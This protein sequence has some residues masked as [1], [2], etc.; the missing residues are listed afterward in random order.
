MLT[1]D[2]I[3]NAM[4][5][6]VS[7]GAYSAEEVDAFLKT[8]AESHEQ[9]LQ[10]NKE[11]IKK[12]SI[13]ADKLESYR[14]DEEAI[15]L[16]LLDARRLAETI[17]KDAN[18]KA[19][20]VVADAEAKSKVIIDDATAQSNQAIAEARE[21]AK[22]IVDNARVAVTAL[23]DR[24]QNETEQAI[25]AA[26][27]KATE[28]VL[29]AEAQGREIIGRSKADFEYY[30][31]ELERIRKETETYKATAEK[32]CKEQLAL[33]E[34]VKLPEIPV[35][36]KA[37][38]VAEVVAQPVVEEA[39]VADAETIA[40]EAVVEESISEEVAV[41]VSEEPAEAPAESEE[42]VLDVLDVPVYEEPVEAEESE[43][44]DND[45]LFSMIE[46][47]NFDDIVAPEE[48][49]ATL[50]EAVA[51]QA[52]A[53]SAV[54]DVI[55]DS[56]DEDPEEFE[57]FEID[58]EELDKITSDVDLSEDEDITSLFDSFFNE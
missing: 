4:F 32:L 35:A 23:T 36:E 9:A 26:Q 10:D 37:E 28:I 2:Q 30:S 5:T 50:D 22:E 43:T 7:R 18:I 6:P 42:D 41:L 48:I 13:L 1:T 45:D 14:S 27:Q 17:N 54:A 33:L 31:C 34:A 21:K 15:K 52:A 51:E 38:P 46:E 16:A 55:D 3:L 58:L 12:I 24:A 56:D 29:K 49:P 19:E 53:E 39:P 57:G 47:L 40:E 44:D 11:L 20:A 8:V 25:T